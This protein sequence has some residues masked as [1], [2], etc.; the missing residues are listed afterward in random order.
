MNRGSLKKLPQV[1]REVVSS[2]SEDWVRM[3][4]FQPGQNLPVVIR[5]VTD[6]ID[7]SAWVSSNRKLVE[8]FLFDHGGVLFRGFRVNSSNDL[9]GFISS[10]STRW[11]E[12]KEAA[13]PRSHVSG[14]IFTSTDYPSDQSIFLH[15]ENSH[16]DSWP[17]K[18][19]FLCL[20]APQ[21]GGETPIA[22]CR[23]VLKRLSPQI[24]DRFKE[25]KILYVRNFG[26]G[27][28]FPWQSVFKTAERDEVE[29]YCRD[30]A[31]QIE[32]K[33][34]NRLKIKY[35]REAVATHPKTGEPVWFN[36]ATFFHAARL[37]LGLRDALFSEFAEED[38]PYNT[39][40]GDGSRI[41]TSVLESLCE[42]YQQETITFSWQ[43]S[44]ILMLDNMLVAHGRAAFSGPR[45]IVVGMADPYGI[46]NF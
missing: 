14:N 37:D 10:T 26:D 6:G 5:P 38:L 11:A 30:A 45:Q 3:E 22:D 15:N 16:C 36:H 17:L 28:G 20:T 25:K 31:I 27:F 35:V 23:K 1:R 44:D 42:A 9:E 29:Q 21:A 13:T 8:S 24:V 46:A 40:Y 18:I 12:Y 33:Y 43:Q 7:L 39:Y 32:W 19:Y 41:E 2:S 4:T 34:G